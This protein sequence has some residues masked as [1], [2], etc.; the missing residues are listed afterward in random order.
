MEM[1]KQAPVMSLHP[2]KRQ[3]WPYVVGI[4]LIVLYL[5]P[6]YVLINLSLREI[7]DLSSRLY[8]P[9]K[10][11][12]YNYTNVLNGELLWTGF[13]NSIALAS[14]T[15]LIEI[16]LGSL[17]AYGIAR[18]NN[19]FTNS[20][21][22]LNMAIMMIPSLALLVG[23]YSIMS[24]LHMINSLNGLAMLAAAG[25]LPSTIFFYTN[26]ITAIP[27]ALDEAAE[28]DGAGVVRTFFQIILPQLK[29]IT[30]TRIIVAFI[31]SWNSYLMPMYMLTQKSKYT[32]ILVI[33]LAFSNDNGTGNLPEA[34]AAC[35]LGLLPIIALYLFLQKYIIQGQIESAVK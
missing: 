12:W 3:V 17:A 2:S 21:R 11:V 26:F 22:T 30:V 7:T 19:R 9:S 5:F 18:L 13:R 4:F 31:G 14:E 20:F 33:K 29:P 16:L 25:G 24:Q 1:K 8:F 23:T 27:T 28:I 34:A 35:A 6:F 15:V 32:I 10:A